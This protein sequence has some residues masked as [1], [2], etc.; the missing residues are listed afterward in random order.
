MNII[1]QTH[2]SKLMFLK[3]FFHTLDIA[4]ILI[5]GIVHI[6]NVRIY[7]QYRLF[8]RIRKRINQTIVMSISIRVFRISSGK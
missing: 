7:I 6:F 3:I 1:N 8:E 5:I 4:I 2:H